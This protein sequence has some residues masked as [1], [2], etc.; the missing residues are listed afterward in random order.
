MTTSTATPVRFTQRPDH[1]LVLGLSATRAITLAACVLAVAIVTVASGMTTGIL[2]AIG[3]SPVAGS[4]LL[5]VEGRALI[6]WTPDAVQYVWRGANGRLRYL[7]KPDRPTRAG[8]LP[9]PGTAQQLAV[10]AAADGSAILHDTAADTWTAIASVT[11]NGFLYADAETQDAATTGFGRALAAIGSDGQI[12][13]IH[14]IHRTQPDTVE[15][16]GVAEATGTA[17]TR[18]RDGA[19]LVGK[20]PSAAAAAYAETL[21]QFRAA[22][23]HETLLAVT[24]GG[25]TA[26]AAIRRVG[27]GRTAAARVLAAHRAGLAETLDSADTELEKW[28]TPS[29]LADWI[30]DGVDPASIP[31]HHD[32]P[33]GAR[34]SGSGGSVD[35]AASAGPMAVDETWSTVRTDS[36]WHQVLWVSGWPRFDTH[37]AFLAPVILPAGATV[38]VSLV[39]EPIPTPV[40]LRQIGRDKTAQASDA[41]L[42]RRIGTL[43]TA[44][45]AAREADTLQREAEIAEGHLDMRHTALIAITAATRDE[46]GDAATRNRQAAAAAGCETRILYGQQLAALNA[47]ILPAGVR[48]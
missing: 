33:A 39:Y 34:R 29:D 41:A 15:M 25:K 48:L 7:A 32:G 35:A 43:D 31:L 30:I 20:S 37:P 38:T 44:E 28:L 6:E 23:R 12:Q 18:R 16:P 24:L 19:D 14:I 8:V 47:T 9:I 40:A 1:S 2:T 46:L 21:S 10:F 3:I 4:A 13:R 22:W 11:G 26:R 5:M 45:Q 42:R 17:I 36:A 27:H